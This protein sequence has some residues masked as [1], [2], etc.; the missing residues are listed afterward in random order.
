MSQ[1]Q[2][3]ALAFLRCKNQ[4]LHTGYNTAFCKTDVLLLCFLKRHFVFIVGENIKGTNS[5]TNEIHHYGL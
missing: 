2:T 1:T 4:L 5:N 3:I